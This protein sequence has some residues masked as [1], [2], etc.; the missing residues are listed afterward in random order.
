MRR[1]IAWPKLGVEFSVLGKDKS[2][3]ALTVARGDRKRDRN[4][5]GRAHRADPTSATCE[6]VPALDPV[7]LT[8]SA[9]FPCSLAAALRLASSDVPP[10]RARSLSIVS[11]GCMRLALRMGIMDGNDLYLVISMAVL[12]PRRR[13]P[14]PSHARSPGRCHRL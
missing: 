9:D 11:I 14:C 3:I 13:R 2:R 5:T 12:L 1:E 8:G 4:G 10:R 6:A 7:T